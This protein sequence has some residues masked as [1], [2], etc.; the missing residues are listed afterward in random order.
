MEPKNR[1]MI[2]AAVTIL[3]LGAILTSFGKAMLSFTPPAVVLPSDSP[4]QGGSSSG[5]DTG[6]EDDSLHRVAVTPETVQGVIATLDRSNSYY[7]ELSLETFW[8]D[9][10]ALTQVNSWTDD[11]WTHSR[12]V[13][14]SGVV[15]HDLVGE[16]TLYYWYDGSSRCLTA[17]ADQ[18]SADLSQRI[19]TYE[20]VLAQD[21]KSISDAGYDLRDDLP[22]IYVETR[23]EKLDLLTRFWISV[24][25]GLLVSA[26]Q[27]QAGKL[28]YRMTSS[29]PTQYP[30][31]SSASFTLPD[32]TVLHSVG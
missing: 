10:S 27:E 5:S 8:G 31:P 22:C 6:S 7:R 26:E 18:N 30:C 4:S 25:S 15:R 29:G 12:L 14:P 2:V 11:G 9:R 1:L 32:G 16:D 3:I 17:K 23:D 20:T 19:P 28:V 24:E 21:M 13:L